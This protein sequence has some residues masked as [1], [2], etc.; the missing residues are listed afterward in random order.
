MQILLSLIFQIVRSHPVHDGRQ[1]AEPAER[2]LNNYKEECDAKTNKGKDGYALEAATA[3][4]QREEEERQLQDE[5]GNH[6]KVDGCHVNVLV[7][8]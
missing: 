4:E 2:G 5:E 6:D 3:T 7:D 8:T 1:G